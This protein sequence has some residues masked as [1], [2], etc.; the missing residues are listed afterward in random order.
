MD[1]IAMSESVLD[2]HEATLFGIR[3]KYADIRAQIQDQ[4]MVDGRTFER[5]RALLSA[6]QTEETEIVQGKH[7]AKIAEMRTS[8][9]NRLSVSHEFFQ[10][11][12]LDALRKKHETELEMYR[13]H[14]LNVSE[15]V[16][17]QASEVTQKQVELFANSTAQH[18]Q[19][20]ATITN[21][22]KSTMGV[23]QNVAQARMRTAQIEL[24]AGKITQ[25]EYERSA[26]EAGVMQERLIIAQG[27]F[28]AFMGISEQAQAVSAFA[29]GFTNPVFF[30][31]GLAHQAAAV[32]HFANAAM[33]P[34]MA[35][36]ARVANQAGLSG[37]GGG[38]SA[39]GGGSMGTSAG[40]M[41]RAELSEAQKQSQGIQ[42]GDI[43]LADIPYL[44]NADG[45]TAL[46]RH[47]A[48]AVVN[49][50][51]NNAQV[52]GGYRISRRASRRS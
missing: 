46:G 4:E 20:A 49:E 42:F 34:E 5:E 11:S 26:R 28:H 29:K 27:V 12:E 9:Q 16:Q 52:Q 2:Q 14:G 3:K 47:I 18:A 13:N 8:L 40:Y 7:D 19:M 1:R 30:A 31:Q 33:A 21:S 37:G 45:A 36:H 24:K 39:G 41:E 44:F 43:V 38:G 32:A 25:A 22:V 15:L 23:F 17:R 10:M 48:G 35:R 51:N 50:V 6:K